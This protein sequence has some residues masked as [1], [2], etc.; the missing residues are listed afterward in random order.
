MAFAAIDDVI[1]INVEDIVPGAAFER[2]RAFAA[3]HPIIAAAAD[4]GVVTSTAILTIIAFAADEGVITGAATLLRTVGHA[5]GIDHVI[6]R[7]AADVFDMGRRH[8]DG[9]VLIRTHTDAV[10][11]FATVDNL[12]VSIDVQHVIASAAIH[13]VS[14]RPAHEDVIAIAALHGVHAVAAMHPVI[15]VAADL[16]VASFAA[17]H[18]IVA[19]TADLFDFRLCAARDHAVITITT[20]NIFNVRP[21]HIDVDAFIALDDDAVISVATVD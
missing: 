12:V 15:A 21:G 14:A 1:A 4:D 18:R 5:A 20:L 7:A 2:I 9:E 11:T 16:I 17:D 10:M 8:I 6:A 19:V 3:D 13:L